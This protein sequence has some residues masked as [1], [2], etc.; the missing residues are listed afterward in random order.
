M[1]AADSNVKGNIVPTP[2][3]ADSSSGPKHPPLDRLWLW[4]DENTRSGP[5][6]MAV[7][8]W[9]LRSHPHVPVLRIYRWSQAAVSFGYGEKS[10]PLAA[11]FPGLPLVRRW[12][13]GGVVEHGTD[14]TYTLVL[15]KAVTPAKQNSVAVYGWV[16]KQ[17]ALAFGQYGLPAVC[18]D[19][20]MQVPGSLC[21][22]A[23]VRHDVLV[24]GH[25]VAGAGQ[26]RTLDGLLHQ[27]SLQGPSA[28][29]EV[30][31]ILATLLARE[32]EAVPTAL[33]PPDGE[34]ADIVRA[35]YT[36]PSWTFAR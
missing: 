26:R 12:T 24:G 11:R 6:D 32:V 8:E 33:L 16:H 10:A 5:E 29:S 22:A 3:Q 25:K 36:N 31:E 1:S 13:G 15:P 19:E 4:R 35:R 27:G 30:V 20:G 23:P 17:L 2:V 9:L 34:V 18:V 7:D 28:K 21:F 14:Q